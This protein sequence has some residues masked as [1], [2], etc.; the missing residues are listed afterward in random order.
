MDR[1]LVQEN[2]SLRIRLEELL[3][4]ITELDEQVK[5][6]GARELGMMRELWDQAYIAAITGLSSKDGYG[7]WY[8][9]CADAA[10]IANAAVIKHKE[11][12]VERHETF[13]QLLT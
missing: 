7:Y 8:D 11:V 4:A 12:A 10:G 1:D 5:S 6:S 3:S 9:M 13:K 2:I